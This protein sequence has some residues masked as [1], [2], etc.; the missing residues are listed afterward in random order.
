MKHSMWILNL[1]FSL[2]YIEKAL[3]TD[4]PINSCYNLCLR[5][6]GADV[7]N[8]K[9]YGALGGPLFMREKTLIIICPQYDTNWAALVRKRPFG[10]SY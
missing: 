2:E 9:E 4:W 3:R 10:A 7:C 6:D 5:D 1:I 8:L